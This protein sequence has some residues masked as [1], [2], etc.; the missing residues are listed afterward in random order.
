MKP[1]TEASRAW[2]AQFTVAVNDFEK[3]N[4]TYFVVNEQFGLEQSKIRGA[5]LCD[6][7][8]KVGHEQNPS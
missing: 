8:A 1:T 7:V 3:I 6:C 5:H 2:T 4:T